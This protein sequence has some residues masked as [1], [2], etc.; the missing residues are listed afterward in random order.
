MAAM[1][2]VDSLAGMP[3]SFAGLGVREKTFEALMGALSGMGESAAIS[4]AL[5]GWLM[6]VF[7]AILGGVFFLISRPQ[8]STAS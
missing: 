3:V 5:A 8:P 4:A 7:W 1:P 6:Q 2:I